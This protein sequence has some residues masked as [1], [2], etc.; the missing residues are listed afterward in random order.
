VLRGSVLAGGGLYQTLAVN[1]RQ[2]SAPIRPFHL[3]KAGANGLRMDALTPISRQPHALLHHRDLWLTFSRPF[4]TNIYQ[5]EESKE[6]WRQQIEKKTLDD[7]TVG[8]AEA[9]IEYHDID[10]QLH[11]AKAEIARANGN[12]EEAQKEE[13]AKGEAKMA[14][15]EAKMAK[16]KAE[17]AKAKAVGDVRGEKLA[18]KEYNRAEAEYEAAKKVHDALLEQVTG[19]GNGK[20]VILCIH[21]FCCFNC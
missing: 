3:W 16:A 21:S 5:F 17:M 8:V 19:G 18:E 6:F 7:D 4:A 11:D 2:L 10:M 1:G 15:G 9:K 14:K 13:M 12:H 20:C